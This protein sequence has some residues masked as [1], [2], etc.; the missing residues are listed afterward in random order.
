M[1]KLQGL[2]VEEIEGLI[3]NSPHS[4]WYRKPVVGFGDASDR[5]FLQLKELVSPDHLL[6]QDLLTQANTVM[7]FFVPFSDEIIVANQKA[8]FV[9]KEWAEAYI[10]TNH[11]ISNICVRL[12]EIFSLE[13][14]E[15]AWVE[16][17]HNFDKTKLISYWSHKH[18]AYM[19]GLGSFGINQML[20]THRGCA[21]RVGSM[22]I[23][24]RITPSPKVGLHDYCDYYVSGQCRWCIDACPVGALNEQRFDR[25]RC[26]ER[27]MEVDRFY[28]DLSLCDVCG[29]CAVGPCALEP[30]SHHAINSSQ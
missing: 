12:S 26:Y 16:P 1:E 2:I 4:N 21:G 22:V 18:V 29:K 14:I 20:I 9:A 19:C 13:D 25:R 27:L 6:P 7:A 15:S 30:T 10:V 24:K 5:L 23:N 3:G 8:S 11:L 28:S 17:T